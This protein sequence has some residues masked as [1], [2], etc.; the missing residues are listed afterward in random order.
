MASMPKEDELRKRFWE[1]DKLEK[2]V[3]AKL[4]PMQEERDNYQAK[5]EPTLIKLNAQ[6]KKLKADLKLFDIQ[7]E[8]GQISRALKGKT[9]LK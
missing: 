5:Y 3:L 8:K 1:L 7:T 6:I 9:G 4:K 2:A